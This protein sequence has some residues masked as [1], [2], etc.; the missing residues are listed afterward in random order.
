MPAGWD[1]ETLAIYAFLFN[2]NNDT[3]TGRPLDDYAHLI[4]DE[5]PGL[6]WC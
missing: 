1:T 3:H 6:V 2:A 4:Y 5:M